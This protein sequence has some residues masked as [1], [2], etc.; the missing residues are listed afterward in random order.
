[1][2]IPIQNIFYLF[3]YAWGHFP[4]GSEIDVGDD[5]SPDLQNLLAK[6]LIHSTNHLLRRGLERGYVSTGED[7]KL[8]RGRI[9]FGETVKRTL[10]RSGEIHC[11]ID[12]FSADTLANQI[13][14]ATI[15]R[16]SKISGLDPGLTS[17]LRLLR[18][19]LSDISDVRITR[20]DLRR[21]QLGQNKRYY[22]FILKLCALIHDATLPTTD[23]S[24]FSFYDVLDDEVRMATVFEEFVRNFYQQ[25]QSIY[26]IGPRLIEWDVGDIDDE[27]RALLPNMYNDIRL[28]GA[29]D[30]IVIDT[31][32]YKRT[33]SDWHGVKRVSSSN[34]YQIY[35]YLKNLSP[36]LPGRSL[37]GILIYPVVHEEVDIAI[38]IQDHEIQV[39]TLNLNQDWRSIHDSLLRLI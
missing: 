5:E 9:A 4:E 26:N 17:Q 22:R 34:L 28:D 11:L 27:A 32:Y 29:E 23:G 31:K 36:R 16:T 21:V 18:A 1:M 15:V 19:R 25:E 14:K 6:A 39:F 3:C 33:L 10:R 7:T 2:T 24:G 38:P 30:T 8:P 13:I 37:R 20:P 12:E 35:S